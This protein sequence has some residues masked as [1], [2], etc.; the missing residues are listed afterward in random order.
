MDEQFREHLA[1]IYLDLMDLEPMQQSYPPEVIVNE[2]DKVSLIEFI[3]FLCCDTTKYR[4]FFDGHRS[5]FRR[6][7]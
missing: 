7:L 5:F 6:L 4:S 1:G 3:I 2:D